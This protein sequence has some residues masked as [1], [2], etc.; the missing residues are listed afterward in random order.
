IEAELHA[1]RRLAFDRHR[2]DPAHRAKRH[3]HPVTSILGS[4]ATI[5]A[6][7][8]SEDVKVARP[9]RSHPPLTGRSVSPVK[10]GTGA[11]I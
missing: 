5:T 1:L 9:L 8:G 7:K 2:V 10:S 4:A 3:R 6:G 11:S